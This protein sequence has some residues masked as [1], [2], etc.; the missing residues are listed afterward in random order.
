MNFA[1]IMQLSVEIAGV[2]RYG[3]ACAG[4]VCADGGDRVTTPPDFYAV[5][6]RRGD[7]VVL[8]DVR[9]VGLQPWTCGD[10]P[11]QPPPKPLPGL[12]LTVD[13]ATLHPMVS[14]ATDAGS[15]S[16]TPGLPLDR[17]GGGWAWRDG[18]LSGAWLGDLPTDVVVRPAPQRWAPPGSACVTS[19]PV[20]AAEPPEARVVAT[21]H[22]P[23]DADRSSWINAAG[24]T[25]VHAAV[26][27]RRGDQIEV[28]VGAHFTRVRGWVDA[29][30]VSKIAG[31]VGGSGPYSIG[32]A[33]PTAPF[34]TVPPGTPLYDAPGGT[35]IGNTHQS[36]IIDRP[37]TLQLPWVVGVWHTEW[38]NLTVAAEVQAE[39][40][41]AGATEFAALA[42]ANA[43]RIEPSLDC[44]RWKITPSAIPWTLGL[45]C[46]DDSARATLSF[47]LGQLTWT[48]ADGAP[49]RY[50]GP[51]TVDDSGRL[52]TI[53]LTARAEV[54]AARFALDTYTWLNASPAPDAHWTLVPS[55]RA[56]PRR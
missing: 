1:D 29:A 9:S 51:L 50:L 37:P 15:W 35:W 26:L 27:Q 23:T 2:D 12:R 39:V 48:P 8:I 11:C 45:R 19:G 44:R 7:D 46:I 16:L 36:W 56:G 31:A 14:A 52:H 40:Y 28:E 17:A 49:A 20:R 53:D 25:C 18:P 4:S 41:G 24:S 47:D 21:I 10:A 54:A 55:R 13:A 6:D 33:L 22:A 3:L 38:G 5:V 42:D 32:C 43:V 34:L 30:R